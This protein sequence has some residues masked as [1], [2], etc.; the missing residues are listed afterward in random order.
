MTRQA[1]RTAL[2]LV[3]ACCLSTF[4]QEAP[5]Q[6]PLTEHQ[7]RTREEFEAL[8]AWED[9][10]PE[11]WEDA[12][13]E[14]AAE[15]QALYD[16]IGALAEKYT[17]ENVVY[18]NALAD[19]LIAELYVDAGHP[20]L[21]SCAQDI[22]L[23]F[24]AD[25]AAWPEERLPPAARR[26][27]AEGLLGY[28]EAGGGQHKPPAEAIV[29]STLERLAPGYA[30]DTVEWL[31]EDAFAWT[32]EVD[33]DYYR[34]PVYREC[35][36][37]WGD[38]F[39]LRVYETRLG[40]DVVPSDPPE[41]YQ[42]AVAA[43]AAL[44]SEQAGDEK[45]FAKRVHRATGLALEKFKDA[46][47]NDD[48]TCR[49]LIVYRC[50]LA[51]RP[52]IAERVSAYIDDRLMWL[53]ARSERLKTDVHWRLRSQAA[54]A[55]RPT[56]MSDRFKSYIRMT[57]ETKDVPQVRREAARRVADSTLLFISREKQPEA[58]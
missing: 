1:Y 22:I 31:L 25:V 54:R 46:R 50:L 36:R 44:L 58:P 51:R 8:R 12:Y 14:S 10:L 47:L 20:I 24:L 19:Q 4:A 55:L 49:L 33:A 5:R 30:T 42:R 34:R 27:L 15:F 21:N 39:W 6:L 41:R 17:G 2:A 45:D 7:P 48:L 56:R 35:A 32:E 57:L 37:H 52:M 38:V 16:R 53:A 9:S 40:R 23:R 29:A 11:K 13:P 18:D 3:A 26:R 28:I 43:L